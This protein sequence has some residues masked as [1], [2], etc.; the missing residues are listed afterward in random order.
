MKFN[1][2]PF[3]FY[4]M[5]MTLAGMQEGKGQN[6]RKY[7]E[8]TVE[9]EK[10]LSE[11]KFLEASTAYD[12]LIQNYEFVFLREYKIATQLS[13]YLDKKDKSLDLLKRGINAGW[14]LKN[15]KKNNYLKTHLKKSDWKTITQYYPDHHSTYLASLDYTLREKVRRMFKED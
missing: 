11:E 2:F 3:L 7:N 5:V 15:L 10:L 1:L 4:A 14:A 6:Y 13:L 8:Q 9:A 12:Q